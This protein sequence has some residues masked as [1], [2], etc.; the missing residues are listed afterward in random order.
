MKYVRFLRIVENIISCKFIVNI[1]VPKSHKPMY[2][3]I[4]ND[5]VDDYPYWT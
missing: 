1:F 5:N 3:S 2:L 4:W